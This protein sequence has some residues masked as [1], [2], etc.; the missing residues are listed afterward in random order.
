MR[1]LARREHSRHELT[2]KLEYAGADREELAL[3]LD[4]FEA[5]NWLSDRR[6]A[7]SYVADHRAREGAVKLAYALR[8]RGIAD[9]GEKLF[10][11][12]LE[13]RL[14]RQ[15][16]VTETVH[17][18]GFRR[19]TAFFQSMAILQPNRPIRRMCMDGLRVKSDGCAPVV[20][21]VTHQG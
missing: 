20:G 16:H 8:Q 1:L 6:F 10:A 9:K 4:E 18:F 21:F 15:E 11:Q 2:H 17:R 14:V 5:N 12:L 7:E 3:L 19:P 13:Q